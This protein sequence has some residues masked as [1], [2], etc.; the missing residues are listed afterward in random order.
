VTGVGSIGEE[1]ERTADSVH[2]AVPDAVVFPE[3][4]SVKATDADFEA[5]AGAAG[6]RTPV[7]FTST[8]AAWIDVA[9]PAKP[10][11]VPSGAL[12]VA[13]RL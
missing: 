1:V 2:V 13:I 8:K 7:N 6:G 9:G 12:A 3:L 4:F 10:V 5:A 11:V